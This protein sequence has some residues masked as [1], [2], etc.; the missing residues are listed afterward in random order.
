MSESKST[1]KLLESLQSRMK[2][3]D[4][5]YLLAGKS[6]SNI[7]EEEMKELN[8]RWHLSCYKSC[9]HHHH[10]HHHHPLREDKTFGNQTPGKRTLLCF[11]AWYGCVGMKKS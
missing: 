6:F 3:G 4:T 9:T 1:R 5:E 11:F 10:H 7:S 8:V 2:Y